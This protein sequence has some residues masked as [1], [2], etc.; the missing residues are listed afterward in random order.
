[1]LIIQLVNTFH[2]AAESYRPRWISPSI[3]NSI[4]SH[5]VVVLTG[6]RQVGKRAL[7]RSEG[8]FRDWP[9]ITFDDPDA[10]QQ[11]ADDPAGLW[12]GKRDRPG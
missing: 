2:S 12:V 10:A 11:A 8:P 1:V 3:R 9:Y 4:E 7:L 6:A 5:P